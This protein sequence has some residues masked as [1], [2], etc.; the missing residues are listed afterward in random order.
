MK[1]IRD[2]AEQLVADVSP[3]LDEGRVEIL[4]D[5]L[6]A[7]EFG[8]GARFAVGYAID[9]NVAVDASLIEEFNEY[10]G[11]HTSEGVKT[12]ESAEMRAERLAKERRAEAL[13][14]R[15][16]SML[17][18]KINAKRLDEVTFY[19]DNGEWEI[20]I[21]GAALYML[22]EG[23]LI[24]SEVLEFEEWFSTEGFRKVKSAIEA[25]NDV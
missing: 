8:E 2:L 4:G 18:G 10:F 19:D 6:F 15:M 25:Q 20:A 17:A 21:M 3:G 23:I 1:P 24:P 14:S 5:F 9:Q 7:G 12:K 22:D 16:I 13:A 11:A